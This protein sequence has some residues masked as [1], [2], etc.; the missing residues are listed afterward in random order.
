MITGKWD[1]SSVMMQARW[2][3]GADN[4]VELLGDTAE[5]PAESLLSQTPTTKV[6]F[7]QLLRWMT[8]ISE[9]Q[10]RDS[11]CTWHTRQKCQKKCLSSTLEA[12]QAAKTTEADT[13]EEEPETGGLYL[14]CT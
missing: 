2:E 3:G 14:A 1:G 8:W 13:G 4:W 9:T 5:S 7:N 10:E 12:G 6:N 11:R